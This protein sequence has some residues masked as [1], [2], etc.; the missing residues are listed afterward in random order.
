MSDP[1]IEMRVSPKYTIEKLRAQRV[2]DSIDVYED[3]VNGWLL[4]HA[5]SLAERPHSEYA[6]LALLIGY[7][8]PHASYLLGQ[9]SRNKSKKCFREG[10]LD[11]F[12]GAESH[13]AGMSMPPNFRENLADALYEEA[14][15]G[16]SHE[17][18]IRRRILLSY[19]TTEAIGVSVKKSTGNIDAICINP[20]RVLDDITAHLDRYVSALRDPKNVDLRQKFETA[21]RIKTPHGPPVHLPPEALR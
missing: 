12:P 3:R 18:L 17:G 15:C 16:V 7:F 11:V 5:R 9:D 20:R 6:V 13:T 21:C 4:N 19:R 2:E 14:R 8:E 1:Q 10:F